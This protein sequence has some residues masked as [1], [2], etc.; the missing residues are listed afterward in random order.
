MARKKR[1]IKLLSLGVLL[2]AISFGA[3]ALW[4]LDNRL[5]NIGVVETR[6][7]LWLQ[8]QLQFEMLR[9]ERELLNYKIGRSDAEKLL[10]RFDI[11][12]SR[13]EVLDAPRVRQAIE[14]LDSNMAAIDNVAQSLPDFDMRLDSLREI[15]VNAEARFEV[16]VILD[17]IAPL[18]EELRE[19]SLRLAQ[20]KSSKAQILK[21]DMLA[22]SKWISWLSLAIIS[23][24][25]FLIFT[26]LLESRASQRLSEEMR[27]LAE[28]AQV[29]NAAKANFIS[30]VSHEMRTPLTSI[31]GGIKLLRK[32]IG[33]KPPLQVKTLIDMAD[34]NGERLLSFVNDI[35]DA[36]QLASGE[37]KLF[38]KNVQILPLVQSAIDD[39]QQYGQKF[40]VQYEIE[41][42]AVNATAYVDEARI[43]QVIVNLL[44][45]AAK[46]SHPNST[47]R[48]NVRQVD[49][50]V[51][52]E[53]E[54][55]GIGID[56][57]DF[58]KIFSPFH[59]ALPGSTG[60]VKSTGL[61][62]SISKKLT[63]LHDGAIGF[64]SKK[65]SGSVFWISIPASVPETE[66]IHSSS[67]ELKV[68]S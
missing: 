20:S 11:L 5:R 47:V 33:E 63:E 4:S 44:S 67:S 6:D 24:L 45:N 57:D 53:V 36:E 61:G 15:D 51:I 43:S 59:Q 46:F 29:A 66:T 49:Y 56:E 41:P 34:R 25:S 48:V 1:I 65:G 35:L 60:P 30:I 32:L 19:F 26:F 10:R 62:L 13:V 37:I 12:W 55:F 27:E 58:D 54:D 9:F 8:N 64:S 68:A 18:N 2:C 23:L 38:R 52:I 39:C 42:T 50:K 7:A 14:R 40:D 17:R 28:A 3:F 21:Q 16:D 22:L 31:H